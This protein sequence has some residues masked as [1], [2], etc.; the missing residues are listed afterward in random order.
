[1]KKKEPSPLAYDPMSPAI[2]KVVTGAEKRWMNEQIQAGSS[3]LEVARRTGRSYGVVYR[4]LTCETR[5]A[6][7]KRGSN[8]LF[9]MGAR[10]L[11]HLVVFR[12]LM[13]EGRQ[14]RIAS[15]LSRKLGV[16]K[17]LV[18]NRIQDIEAM[19][20]REGDK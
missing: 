17:R 3:L 9:T 15:R 7:K 6:I 1:M 11:T 16:S 14:H 13:A 2:T 18:Y 20:M 8:P 12:Q 4:W 19:L 5:D 10:T